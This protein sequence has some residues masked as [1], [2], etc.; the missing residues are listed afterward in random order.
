M[1]D[2]NH[3]HQY[4]YIKETLTFCGVD[5]KVILF[6]SS[7]IFS[8]YLLQ[9]TLNIEGKVVMIFCIAT[10]VAIQLHKWVQ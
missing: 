10:S 6:G 3:Q 4:G 7:L 1:S 8:A 5:K 9:I 2:K